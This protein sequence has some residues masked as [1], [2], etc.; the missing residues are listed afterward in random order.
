ME[1]QGFDDN[2]RLCY[3]RIIT[4]DVTNL[5]TKWK[6]VLMKMKDRSSVKLYQLTEKKEV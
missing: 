6:T 3:E 2:E 5:K 4:T 1:N